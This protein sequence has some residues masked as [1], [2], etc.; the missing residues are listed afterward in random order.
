MTM[1][2]EEAAVLLS[3]HSGRNPDIDHPKWTNGFLG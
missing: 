2:K 3:F 1:N